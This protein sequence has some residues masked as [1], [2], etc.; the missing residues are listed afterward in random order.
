MKLTMNSSKFRFQPKMP[1]SNI[2]QIIE[3]QHPGLNLAMKLED[4]LALQVEKNQSKEPR[5]NDIDFL[6]DRARQ[7]TS[8][9]T[10][11]DQKIPRK[12]GRAKISQDTVNSAKPLRKLAIEPKFAIESKLEP[13]PTRTS[14]LGEASKTIDNFCNSPVKKKGPPP[15]FQGCTPENFNKCINSINMFLN[16]TLRSKSAQISQ[17]VF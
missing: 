6:L 17:E 7:N 8:K 2:Q 14:R 11:T 12:L 13:L 15:A 16:L 5:N 9:L 3:E 1:Q 4:H 10:I